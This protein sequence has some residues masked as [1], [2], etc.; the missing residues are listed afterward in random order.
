MATYYPISMDDMLQISGISKGKALKYAKPFIELIKEYVDQNEI[1]RPNDIVI[2]QVA[3]KSKDKVTIIQAIDR[4]LPFE[5]IAKSVELTMDDLLDELNKM[6]DGGTKL[7]IDYY[8]ED[9]IDED[10]IEEIYEYFHDAESASLDDAY[11]ELK[12]EDINMEELALVRIKFMS[13][14]VN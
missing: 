12:E 11:N 14:V 10:I 5:D 4:K 13:E 3:N 2:K 8:I 9:M 6:V 7:D 1:E